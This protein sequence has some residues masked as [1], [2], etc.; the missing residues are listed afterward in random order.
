MGLTFRSATSGDV[1]GIWD[2]LLDGKAAL[3]RMG[4]DQWQGSYPSKAVVQSDVDAHRSYVIEEDGTILAT[5]V[6]GFS[7]EPTY[8]AIDGAWLTSSTSANPR[9]AVL[10]R[11]ASLST[12]AGRGLGR[13]LLE[14]GVQTAREHCSESVRIETHP[15]NEPMLK[16]IERCGFTRCG[17]TRIDHA[18]GGNPNRVAFEMLL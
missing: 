11:V 16:L 3:K 8:D 2:V 18:E 9:Y 4:I 5:A 17:I 10:H 6:V 7:G 15:D 1:D 14:Y 13:M 12:Q